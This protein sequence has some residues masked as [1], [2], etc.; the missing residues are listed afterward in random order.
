MMKIPFHNPAI[1]TAGDVAAVDTLEANVTFLENEF[2]DS[3][4]EY[5]EQGKAHTNF[6][7]VCVGQSFFFSGKK[8]DGVFLKTG[9]KQA[10]LLL[11]NVKELDVAATLYGQGFDFKADTLVSVV[12]LNCTF[13]P[14][15]IAEAVVNPTV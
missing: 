11:P 14:P 13:S 3:L 15:A 1:V 9:K 5:L 2:H 12:S 10:M 6:S 7:D 4:T 8:K